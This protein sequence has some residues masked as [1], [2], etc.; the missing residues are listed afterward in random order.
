MGT[1]VRRR[2]QVETTFG[3]IFAVLRRVPREKLEPMP[4]DPHESVAKLRGRTGQMLAD[5]AALVNCESPSRAGRDLAVC[6]SVISQMFVNHLG[7]SADLLPPAAGF[8]TGPHVSWRGGGSP[9]VLILGHYDTVFPAGTVTNRPF[10]CDGVLARGPGVF[11][12]KAAIVQAVF[13]IA[14][15]PPEVREK[16]EVLFTSDEEIGSASSRE[17]LIDRAKA[18]GTALV[19]EPSADGGALKTARKGTGTIEVVCHGRA[20][21]A[22]LEPEKGIN[23]LVEL[24]AQVPVISSFANPSLGTTVTPTVASAGTADNVVPA[25]ARMF[26]DVRVEAPGE[27]ERI[28][29]AFASLSPVVPGC[30]I[31]VRGAIGRPPM[32]ASASAD[33]MKV[34]SRCA[35]ELGLGPISGVAVGGGSDGNFTA[36]AGVPTLDGLGAV[37]GG[38]HGDTEHVIVA[39]MPNRAALLA[40]IIAAIA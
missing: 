13:A 24:A 33:L 30:T 28:E 21:H 15:L 19:L 2:G 1:T 4:A 32:P 3:L 16:V 5:L 10:E 25:E 31:E 36:A 9:S 12:M 27:K 20:S 8:A 14:S 7:K 35:D 29:A 40:A 23:A 22:G 26:V 17:L 37:G 38:A 39:E 6:A 18:C 34:A 11:D